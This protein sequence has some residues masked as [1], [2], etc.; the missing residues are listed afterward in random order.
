MPTCGLGSKR[1]STGVGPGRD[2]LQ[3]VTAGDPN[4]MAAGLSLGQH[5]A[6][7]ACVA[8]SMIGDC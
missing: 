5:L 7:N 2:E 8:F 4:V 3:H 1:V 6:G